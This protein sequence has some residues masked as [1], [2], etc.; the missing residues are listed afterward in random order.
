MNTGQPVTFCHLLMPSNREGTIVEINGHTCAV[1]VDFL[2]EDGHENPKGKIVRHVLMCEVE[3][4]EIPGSHWQ[5]CWPRKV[6]SE[7]IIGVKR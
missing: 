4:A 5:A 7:K 1:A 6:E 3:P 2:P